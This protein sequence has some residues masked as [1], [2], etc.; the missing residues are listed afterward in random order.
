VLVLA[1]PFIAPQPLELSFGR[2]EIGALLVGVL[3]G[4]LVSGDG[5]S[6]WYKGVQLITLYLII[7]LLCYFVP[8][9]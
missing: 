8:Q 3:L 1:S 7:A 5:E 4:T 9:M 2:A 6:N